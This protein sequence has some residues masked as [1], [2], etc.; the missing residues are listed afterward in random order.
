VNFRAGGQEDISCA[1]A[2]SNG[3]CRVISEAITLSR[4]ELYERVWSTPMRTLAKTL[5]LSDV[6]LAK[7][8][9]RMKIPRPGLG[10]WAKK[11]AGKATKKTPL[12]D[13]PPNVGGIPLEA[14]FTP[15]PPTDDQSF[16]LPAPVAEQDEYE[17]R[18]ENRIKVRNTLH[19]GH[20]L[21][22]NANRVLA[23][24]A[25]NPEE[26]VGSWSEA[27]LDI[28]VS[29][30]QLN[31][32]LRV[33]D[34]LIKAFER[35]GWKVSIA[36][37]DDRKT[38][39]TVLGRQVP[40]GIR[41][42]IKKVENPPPKPVRLR[43]GEW[44]TPYQTKYQDV[45]SGRLALVLRDRWGDSVNQ[46]WEDSASLPIE[47]QLNDFVVGLVARAHYDQEWDRKREE[48]ERAR[49]VEQQ[50]RF[51]EARRREL[52]AARGREL[53]IE[54]ENWAK[55]QQIASYLAEIRRAAAP[56]DRLEDWL[57]WAESCVQQL[58]PFHN[59]IARSATPLAS[60]PVRLR[61]QE[62]ENVTAEDSS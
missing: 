13:L 20:P 41:E 15:A 4:E 60:A 10:Y 1:F 43:T 3:A 6:G 27:H 61:S 22:Q 39:V 17:T 32:A 53:E 49:A 35:R 33:M 51:E 14:R 36:T 7:T 28:R 57:S 62:P 37:G 30:G 58:N 21:I 34:A 46:S 50:R 40:F 18:P 9:K 5:G 19:S 56:D 25:K 29:R 38:Y 26:F 23:P 52:E 12:P 42:K 47:D 8:C 11:A 24:S 44:Y 59:R 2:Y 54:A 48:N 55:S 16:A 31:R 45:P